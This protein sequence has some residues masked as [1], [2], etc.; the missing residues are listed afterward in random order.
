MK[1][2]E[3]RVWSLLL[4]GNNGR[5]G[6]WPFFLGKRLAEARISAASFKQSDNL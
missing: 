4:T 1:N 3:W 2:E 6:A 5:A